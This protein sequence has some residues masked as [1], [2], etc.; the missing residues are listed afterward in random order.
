MTPARKFRSMPSTSF[1]DSAMIWAFL[2]GIRMSSFEKDRPARV[3]A[4]KP[5]SLMES[6]TRRVASLPS[7]LK[8]WLMTSP[9]LPFVSS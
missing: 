9:M 6:S 8:Q 5:S 7:R 3:A 4:L 1:S 2:P